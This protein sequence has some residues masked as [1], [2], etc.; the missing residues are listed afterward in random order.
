MLRARDVD[1]K[2]DG[3]FSFFH[4]LFDKWT[5]VSG[6]DIPVDNPD[7]VPGGILPDFRKFH[8]PAF[9]STLILA[10]HHLIDNPVGRNLDPSYFFCKIAGNHCI[11]RNFDPVEDHP[12]QVIG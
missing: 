10:C 9:E 8:T 5:L 11:L 4:K 3:Q 2:Q 12:D 7:I 1:E 6:S